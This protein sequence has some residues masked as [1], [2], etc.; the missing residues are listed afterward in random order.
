MSGYLQRL[1]SSVLKPTGA[2]HPIVGSLFAPPQYGRPADA[3]LMEEDVTAGTALP[4]RM[5]PGPLTLQSSWP[6]GSMTETSFSQGP[7]SGELEKSTSAGRGAA[8]DPLRSELPARQKP[9][10]PLLSST[11]LPGKGREPATVDQPAPSRVGPSRE[12][13][14]PPRPEHL[15]EAIVIGVYKPLLPEG[16]RDPEVGSISRDAPS[17]SLPAAATALRSSLSR[18]DAGP[19]R[20]VPDEIQIHIGRIEVTAVPPAVA[21]PPP[22]PAPKSVSLEE[23]LKRRDRRAR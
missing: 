10:V 11:R 4:A 9:A 5:S 23:Y 15:D 21:P 13:A 3:F 12:A 19:A 8:R 20:H 18:P 22:K 2:I 17:W 14:R 1:A 16:A 6:P 7:D